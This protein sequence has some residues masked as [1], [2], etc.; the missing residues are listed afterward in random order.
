[1]SFA[2][3][4]L[5]TMQQKRKGWQ[6][7]FEAF[8]EPT[9]FDR[10][11]QDVD[12]Y[13]V[14]RA[15][16]GSNKTARYI[17]S[18]SDATA[19]LALSYGTS[20]QYGYTSGGV[21]YVVN[22]NTTTSLTQAYTGNYTSINVA[23]T[24]SFPSSGTLKFNDGSAFIYTSKT[25]TSF[26]GVSQLVIQSNGANISLS[27]YTITWSGT[28]RW[29]ITNTIYSTTTFNIGSTQGPL[30]LYCG[31]DITRID[32]SGSG[33]GSKTSIKWVHLD[34]LSNLLYCGNHVQNSNL[35]GNLYLP[36]N[37]SCDRIMTG[38][39][40][41]AF[42][43]C[44]GLTGTLN[45]PGNI[46]YINPG[47]WNVNPF[48]GCTGFTGLTL[49]EG[50]ETICAG[51]FWGCTSMTGTLTIPST[52][53]TI[54]ATA[55]VNCYFTHIVSNSTGFTVYDEV[56]YD[57]TVDGSI[58]A[59]HGARGYSG[60][61]TLK[62]GCT[63][64]QTYCCYN[65]TL[66][67]G[68]L[69]ILNTITTIGA[70]SFNTCKGLTSL[71][72]EATS[73]CTIIKSQAFRY[74]SNLAGTLTL[75]DSLITL[76][77]SAF[78]YCSKY[79]AVVFGNS[80]ETIGKACF[81]MV[82]LTGSVTFPDTLTTIADANSFN[83]SYFTSVYISSSMV[84]LGGIGSTRYITKFTGGSTNY[85]LSDNVIY[86]CKT[87]GVV[88]AYLNANAYV[89]SLTLRSD[90]TEIQAGSFGY[91]K[92]TGTLDIPSTVVTIGTLAFNNPSPNSLL[93]TGFSAVTSSSTNYPASDNVLYDVKT[94]G[95]VKA[96]YCAINSTGTLTFRADTTSIEANCCASCDGRT[97]DLII[98]STVTSIGSS[99]FYYCQG[100][101]GALTI[102]STN[103][104]FNN[105]IF[106]WSSEYP[107]NANNFTALNL[108][109]GFSNTNL[110]FSFCYKFSGASLDASILNLTSATKTMHLGNSKGG[111]GLTN[112]QRLLAY[113]A[114]AVTDAAARGITV[115]T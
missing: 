21:D 104:P 51:A 46:K 72:F 59:N 14:F 89:G 24:S 109:S 30:W 54:E 31:P 3:L 103:I 18:V 68:T 101:A 97:G 7:G 37:P 38:G 73:V 102:E 42:Y 113:N 64:V 29:V 82:P 9:G 76:E 95:Q 70:L 110:Y 17:F 40:E 47:G 55:F 111:D 65:N 87:A 44:T 99:A 86:D 15:Y 50:N 28:K 23:D 74:D 4:A 57:I 1:M 25:A 94:S 63:E 61:I 85:P 41:L 39:Y 32:T 34:K 43:Y 98:P 93:T 49:N 53:T 96:I 13:E 16:W 36:T 60:S 19:T 92:R 12:I 26:S 52:M 2:P 80:L 11:A 48:T 81:Y 83:S 69:Q 56:L 105:A 107:Y 33:F 108:P 115:T 5:A 67:T 78:G 6:L 100:F 35:S 45:I 112:I 10:T 71:T 62:S 20:Y 58:K 90:T 106:G 88:K 27:T 8:V 77:D 79:T 22:L 84:T 91:N 66:R 114:N 75:P